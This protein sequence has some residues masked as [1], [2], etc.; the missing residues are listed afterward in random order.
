MG[1]DL[2]YKTKYK[3]TL[4]YFYKNRLVLQVKDSEILAFQGNI[5]IISKI[6]KELGL[7]NRYQ[8]MKGCLVEYQ[9]GEIKNVFRSGICKS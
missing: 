6:I 3:D 8:I 1:S 2:W 4:T 9:N 5:G 7:E